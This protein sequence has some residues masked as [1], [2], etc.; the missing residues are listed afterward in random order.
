VDRSGAGVGSRAGER[1]WDPRCAVAAVAAV[2][3]FEWPRPGSTNTLE[4]LPDAL[5]VEGFDFDF[6][7]D[8]DAEEPLAG[9]PSR[10]D[11]ETSGRASNSASDTPA[12]ALRSSAMKCSADWCRFSLSAASA[13]RMTSSTC[14]GIGA[15]F[16]LEDT[17]GTCWVRAAVSALRT[18]LAPY[19]EVPVRQKKSTA[20]SE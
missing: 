19:G 13:L 11:S 10:A 5:E 15:P 4:A 18:V 7:P 3:G 6:E 12:M 1:D 17:E 20:P 9:V 2:L 8:L 16:R 14:W